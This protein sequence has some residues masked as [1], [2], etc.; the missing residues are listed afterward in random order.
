[1]LAELVNDLATKLSNRDH[2]LVVAESCTGGKLSAALTAC[3]G[4]SAWFE[5]GFITY[6]NAAKQE[7]LAVDAAVIDEFGAV[8]EQTVRQMAAGALHNS[9]ANYALA[10]TGIAGPSGGTQDK[11][12]GCVWFAIADNV[13]SAINI[14]AQRADFSGNRIEVQSQATEFALRWLLLH[15]D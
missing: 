12:V 8:S 3:A 5:R 7:C 10:I 13:T 14:T 2:S 6:S 15:L 11:P 9:N 4:C 1:M